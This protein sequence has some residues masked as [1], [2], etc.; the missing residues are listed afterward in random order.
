[1]KRKVT[2][3]GATESKRVPSEIKLRRITKK[4]LQDELVKTSMRLHYLR[5][6]YT[7][8]RLRFGR[9]LRKSKESMISKVKAFFERVFGKSRIKKL[10]HDV[11]RLHL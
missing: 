11:T 1:M 9:L 10:R 6:R 5:C 4:E 8:L 7:F 2:K 3:V